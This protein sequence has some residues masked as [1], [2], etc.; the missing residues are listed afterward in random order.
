MRVFLRL[1]YIHAVMACVMFVADR[2]FRGGLRGDVTSVSL[3]LRGVSA[4][5]F[6]G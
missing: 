2:M 3:A 4:L 5:L 1:G 6:E